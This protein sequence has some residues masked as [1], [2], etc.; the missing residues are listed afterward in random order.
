MMRTHI[1]YLFW[2]DFSK[3]NLKLNAAIYYT[4]NKSTS[5]KSNRKCEIITLW[6]HV[7]FF[8]G[9]VFCLPVLHYI[10]SLMLVCS[11]IYALK[12]NLITTS[13]SYKNTDTCKARKNVR[14]FVG[15]TNLWISY[16][17]FM[18]LQKKR[19]DVKF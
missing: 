3:S 19:K 14:F 10:R 13:R 11:L 12:L 5:Q 1:R 16:Q 6:S 4:A 2:Y 8:S 17:K 15:R 7:P 18:L 9:I